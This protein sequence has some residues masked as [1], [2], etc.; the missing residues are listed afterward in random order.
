MPEYGKTLKVPRLRVR[1]DWFDGLVDD[2]V[3]ATFSLNKK[4]E[5]DLINSESTKGSG[6]KVLSIEDSNNYQKETKA[7]D[8]FAG[9]GG[10]LTDE[11]IES[12]EV[13]IGFLLKFINI[14]ISYFYQR[15]HLVHLWDMLNFRKIL[16][17]LSS[18]KN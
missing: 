2:N 14:F 4:P 5:D 11:G 9:F 17:I 13:L 1:K 6:R 15:I 8:T 12:L 10:W 18:M 3:V 7:E 16:C